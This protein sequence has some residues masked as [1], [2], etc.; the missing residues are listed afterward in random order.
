MQSQDAQDHKVEMA[1]TCGVGSQA[2]AARSAVA[3]AKA[4]A[5]KLHGLAF[6]VPGVKAGPGNRPTYVR[7]KNCY[8]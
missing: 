1:S 4:I 7:P 3:M 6:A 2:H 5:W 8:A